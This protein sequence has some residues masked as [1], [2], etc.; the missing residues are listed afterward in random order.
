MYIYQNIHLSFNQLENAS[1][2]P[3][4]QSRHMTLYL[5]VWVTQSVCTHTIYYPH[6]H[7]LQGM[8][9]FQGPGNPRL[10]ENHSFDVQKNARVWYNNNMLYLLKILVF[11]HCGVFAL[12]L[13]FENTAV[14]YYLSWLLSFLPS[15]PLNSCV[16]GECLTLSLALPCLCGPWSQCDP[17]PSKH[18]WVLQ[19]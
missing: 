7:V 5:K 4:L 13:I 19:L 12:I 9:W 18:C 10:F 14:H 11:V 8:W 1:K 17:L 2:S 3:T 16:Q 6:Q 15:P